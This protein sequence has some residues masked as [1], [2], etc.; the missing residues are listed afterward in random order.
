M[1]LVLSGTNGI[2]R[3]GSSNSAINFSSSGQLQF[4]SQP[5]FYAYGITS[6]ANATVLIFPS[7]QV[8]VGNHYNPNNGIF[9]A[10]VSGTYFFSW[11]AL[12][13]NSPDTIFRYYFRYNGANLRDVHLRQDT[14]GSGADYPTNGHRNFMIDMVAGDTASIY[15]VSDASVV[16]YPGTPATNNDYHV[17]TGFLI[18]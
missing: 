12:G 8:N 13:N 4:P 16:Q 7:I 18:G 9:T 17:F 6:A 2:S 15:Y 1:P 5:R 11:T 3:N 10:P 14:L